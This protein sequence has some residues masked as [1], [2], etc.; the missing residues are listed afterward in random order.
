LLEKDRKQRLG[1]KNDVE[2]VLGHSFFKDIDREALLAKQIE[3]PFKPTI[4]SINDVS[5]FDPKFVVQDV[6]ESLLP[7]ESKQKIQEKKDAF[8]KFGFSS[9]TPDQ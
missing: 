5:N 3:P 7:E 9:S 2:D 4:K 6:A 1:A 8:A